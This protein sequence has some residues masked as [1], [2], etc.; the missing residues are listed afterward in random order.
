LIDSMRRTGHDSG[1]CI[2]LGCGGGILSRAL[3][4]ASYKVHGVDISPA[5]VAIARKRVPSARFEVGSILSAELS[6]CVAVA[7]IGECLNYLFDPGHSMSAIVEVL[8]RI[9]EVL[10]PGGILLFDVAEPG[11][12][13]EGSPRRSFVDGPNWAVLVESEEDKDSQILTRRMTTF[14]Q[15]GKMYRRGHETHRLRLIPRDKLKATLRAMGFRVR[16]LNGYGM[17]KFPTG[18][19]GFL[20]RKV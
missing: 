13:R 20:A 11:R 4:N 1:L 15:V 8:R 18:L 7:A 19:V 17:L 10:K 2:D 6:E 3:I 5:M 14:R 9:H 16:M 12:A